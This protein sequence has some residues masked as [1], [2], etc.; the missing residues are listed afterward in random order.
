MVRVRT[1]RRS[2][3]SRAEHSGLLIRSEAVERVA[4]RAVED[5]LRDREQ[6]S[7]SGFLLKTRSLPVGLLRLR[8]VMARILHI[9]FIRGQA[10][11]LLQLKRQ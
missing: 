9:G 1:K 8:M 2:G 11:R 3:A 6:D 5:F 7:G 4:V 10:Q